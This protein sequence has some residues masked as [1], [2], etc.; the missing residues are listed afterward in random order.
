MKIDLSNK[1]LRMTALG[2]LIVFIAVIL[3]NGGEQMGMKNHPVSSI[4]GRVLFVIGWGLLAYSIVGKP[5]GKTKSVL[6]YGGALGVVIAVMGMKMLSGDI[7]KMFGLLFIVSWI[8][9]ASSVGM[10]KSKKSKMISMVALGSVLGSMVFILPQQRKL[11]IV[12]GPGMP[13]FATSFVLLA[14]ANSM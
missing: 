10:D 6:A 4:V 7:K 12:D 1:K 8:A 2:G 9:F 14:I 5:S 13:L 3:K 11:G